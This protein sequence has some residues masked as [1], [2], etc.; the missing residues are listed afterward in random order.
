M[1]PGPCAG[2][3]TSSRYRSTIGKLMSSMVDASRIT[4]V[5]TGVDSARFGV[6]VEREPA[7]P[8]V[9]FLG[10][11]DWEAN[12]DGVEWMCATMWQRI[13]AGGARRHIPR[14]G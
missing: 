7:G 10:S 3:G 11:M 5:P 14:R 13:R 12:I 6:E 4:V 9:L 1:K 2:S 8:V